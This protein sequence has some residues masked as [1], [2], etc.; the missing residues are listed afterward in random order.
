MKI[1][2]NNVSFFSR[3]SVAA[4]SAALLISSC[5]KDHN[6]DQNAKL[7]VINGV[8]DDPAYTVSVNGTALSSTALDFRTSTAYTS[9]PS[10]ASELVVTEQATGKVVSKTQLSTA[11]NASVSAYLAP[12]TSS[13]AKSVLV[14]QDDFTPPAANKAKVRFVNLSPDA[15]SLDLTLNGQPVPSGT[16]IGFKG[17]SPF[18]EVDPSTAATLQIKQTGTGKVLAT[19]AN[20]AVAAGKFYTLWAVGPPVQSSVS[21]AALALGVINNN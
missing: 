8:F 12:Q 1:L 9:I 4:L 16:N 2:K 5:S 11:A 19:T 13:A 6:S 21:N 3:M 17:F 7:K 18:V 10:G 14:I 20:V 15:G